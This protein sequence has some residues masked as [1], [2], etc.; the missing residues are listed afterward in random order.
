MNKAH[1][2]YNMVAVPKITYAADLWFRPK[3]LCKTDQGLTEA[4]PC[5]LMKCLEPIQCNVAI[6]ITGAM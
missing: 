5:L 4:G 3:I 1:K 2:L 6:S